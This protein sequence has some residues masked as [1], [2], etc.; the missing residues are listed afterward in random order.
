MKQ[1]AIDIEKLS[2]GQLHD[3]RKAITENLRRSAARIREDL[4]GWAAAGQDDSEAGE[5]MKVWA[6]A[7][8]EQAISVHKQFMDEEKR[9]GRA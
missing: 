1:I 5:Q 6:A 9:N 8:D 4:I 2:P 3:L 7:A